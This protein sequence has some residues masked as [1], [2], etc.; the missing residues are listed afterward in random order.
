MRLVVCIL[1]GMMGVIDAAKPKARKKAAEVTKVTEAK[2]P[3]ITRTI[4]RPGI[5]E[6]SDDPKIANYYFSD[7]DLKRFFD[8]WSGIADEFADKANEIILV[9]EV[10]KGSHKDLTEPVKTIGDIFIYLFD[11]MDEKDME[12]FGKLSKLLLVKMINIPD[13]LKEVQEAME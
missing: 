9:T 8:W 5:Y 13:V 1:L 10:V 2:K 7:S 3:R 6:I 4:Q 12:F 11:G